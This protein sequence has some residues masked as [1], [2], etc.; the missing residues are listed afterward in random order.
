[1]EQ[2]LRRA[3]QASGGDWSI[4]VA[5]PLSVCLHAVTIAMVAAAIIFELR[6]RQGRPAAV[7]P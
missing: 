5:S 6:R 1:M 4:L 3:M 7:H 2:N